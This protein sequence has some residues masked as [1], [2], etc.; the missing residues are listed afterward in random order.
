MHGNKKISQLAYKEFQ[1]SLSS[2][3][4]K[5]VKRLKYKW[6]RDIECFEVGSTHDLFLTTK[7]TYL[8]AFHFRLISRIIPTKQF[9]HNIRRAESSLCTFC[10]D[11]TETLAHLFWECEHT[12]LFISNIKHKLDCLFHITYNIT[13]ENWFFPRLEKC[14]KLEIMITTIGKVTIY[15]A[16]YRNTTLSINHFLNIL[17]LEIEKEIELARMNNKMEFFRNKWGNLESITRQN[18]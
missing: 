3:H 9:L 7:N 8:Q 12:Q 11:A 18:L 1:Q 14:T 6:N 13:K 5:A 17:K 2:N 10:S 4:E 15:R 16:Q